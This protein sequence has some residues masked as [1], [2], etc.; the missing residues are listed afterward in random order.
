MFGKLA[1]FLH[2]ILDSPNGDTRRPVVDGHFESNIPG[3]FVI[4][5]LAGAAVV[6]LAMAQGSQ[7]AEY[8]A[9]Q[10]DAA[11]GDLNRYDLLVIGAGASGL[12]A[13]LGAQAHGLRVMVLEKNRIAN[14]IEDFPEGKWIYAEPESMP[15]VGKLWLEGASKEDLLARWRQAV[16]EHHLEV[17]TDE[18]VTALTRRA[19]GVFEI[20]T[21]RGAYLATR[22]VLATGQRGNARK[23]NVPGEDRENVHHRL[24]SPKHYKDEEILVVG[25]GNS[26]VEA[27]LALAEQNRVTLSYRGP[28]FTRVFKDNRG[29]LTAAVESSRIR[30]V[31]RSQVK[32]F[33][34][35][36]CA[37]EVEQSGVTLLKYDRAFVLI[38][39]EPPA[40]F[41]RSLGLGLEGD[42]TG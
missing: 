10:P 6:K 33:D 21:D 14:T 37:L 11:S 36:T 13:A 27:A 29:K 9:A 17:R 39:A 18:G 1:N 5:D 30:V 22:V 31:F 34:D 26:A 15:P 4:G 42:W 16:S 20:R 7:V 35:G 3:L 12:N 2:S 8:I 19:D 28:E 40:E 41:L 32:R 38:G 23:L 25:G 24:Y